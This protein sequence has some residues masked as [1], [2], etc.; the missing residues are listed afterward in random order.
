MPKMEVT[1]RFCISKLEV[2]DINKGDNLAP[3]PLLTCSTSDLRATQNS[4][5]TVRF[6]YRVSSLCHCVLYGTASHKNLQKHS[7]P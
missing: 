2:V 6:Q 1:N 5:N 3:L 4:I 7:Y